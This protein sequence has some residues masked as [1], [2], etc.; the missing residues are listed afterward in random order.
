M[1][2]ADDNYTSFCEYF[3]SLF[4]KNEYLY[5]AAIDL[6][7]GKVALSEVELK[8]VN[9]IQDLEKIKSSR[10][11][12][13]IQK[14]KRTLQVKGFFYKWEYYNDSYLR[15]ILLSKDNIAMENSIKFHEKLDGLWRSLFKRGWTEMVSVACNDPLNNLFPHQ[16]KKNDKQLRKMVKEHVLAYL[17]KSNIYFSDNRIMAKNICNRGEFS[18]KSTSTKTAKRNKIE[19]SK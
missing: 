8:K 15:F 5:I 9:D 11:T 13:F 14:C 16:I 7:F 3:D 17:T 10:S 4:I 2:Q 19:K 12:A 6:H 18:S 1:K